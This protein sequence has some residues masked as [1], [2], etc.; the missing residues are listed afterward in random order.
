MATEY[1]LSYTASEIDEKL[2]KVD[3]NAVNISNLSKEIGDLSQLSAYGTSVTEIL[4]K[5]IS[6][7][8]ITPEEK[9]VLESYNI[10]VPQNVSDE[11]KVTGAIGTLNMS[12]TEFLELFYDGFVV[13]NPSGVTVTKTSIGKDESGLYDMW[14][15]DF[16]PTNYSR[17]ILLSSGMHTYELSASFGLANFIGHLYTDT[18]NEAFDYIRKN[19]RVKV[20]PVVNPWGFNQYPK[21]Y[22]NKNGVNPNRN[23]DFDGQWSAFPVYTPSENEWDV[24]GDSPFSEAETKNVAKWVIDNYNAEFWLDCHTGEGYS[25]ADLWLYYNSDSVILDRINGAITRIETWFKETYGSDCV[26][27]RTVDPADMMR[28]PW[29]NKAVGIPTFTLEHAPKRTTFGTSASNEGADISNY[30]TN[31]S[32]FVQ[33][34]LLEKYRDTSVV[35]ISSVSASN[36]AMAYDEL[37]KTV[38]VTI[39]PTNTTQNKFKWTSSDENVVEVY[40]GTNKAILVNKGVGTATITLANRYNSSIKASFEVEVMGLDNYKI[41]NN[42]TDV[43]TNNDTAIVE[44]NSSY[45]ANLTA[46]GDGTLNV[47][48]TM[49]G[50]DVTSSV[51]SNGVITIDKVTGNIVITASTVQTL[52][53]EIAGLNLGTGYAVENT[54]RILTDYIPVTPSSEIQINCIDGYY[55]KAFEYAE[56]KLYLSMAYC[57]GTLATTSASGTLHE[58]CA[59]IRVLLKKQDETTITEEELNNVQLTVDGI[60]CK[61]VKADVEEPTTFDIPV[62]IGT[63][64][65]TGTEAG[66]NIDST[67]RARTVAYIPLNG[68][69]EHTVVVNT[70]KTIIHRTYYNRESNLYDMAYNVQQENN[71]T[72]TGTKASNNF[73]SDITKMTLDGGH[74][75]PWVRFVFANEDNSEITLPIEGSITIDGITYN[76]V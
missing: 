17:T 1:K 48:V 35:A 32:T 71:V 31:I 23:F 63:I 44:A 43:T 76:F 10:F 42:L 66:E 30:S 16:K 39:A 21:T 37:S 18:D 15:Y 14:E 9:E 55:V 6:G 60:T 28:H 41:T 67:T 29:S 73:Y 75:Y 50:N 5:L 68:G 40:G 69:G 27:K 3:E 45:I 58:D 52:G 36:V 70:D 11:W 19:V 64:G 26:T 61:L 49:G 53:A 7:G 72:I 20:I 62:E 33:E 46:V 8:N 74:L 2:G 57:V 4:L 65:Y 51:Y 56:N 59:Y 38:E 12:T 25:D 13:N 22:G 24:K 47:T 54:A 34:F